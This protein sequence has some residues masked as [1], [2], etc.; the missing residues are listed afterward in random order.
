MQDQITFFI[1]GFTARGAGP[2]LTAPAQDKKFQRLR[3][4]LRTKCAG[5]GSA[6]LGLMLL[7][8]K[9]GVAAAPAAPSPPACSGA[10]GSRK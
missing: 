7:F 3:V 4:R 9:A 6:S 10:H 8:S 2:F 5:S 1:S